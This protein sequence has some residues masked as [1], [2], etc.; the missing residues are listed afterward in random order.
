MA[1][2]RR[3]WKPNFANRLPLN[4]VDSRSYQC[5][6]KVNQWLIQN[7]AVAQYVSVYQFRVCS[8]VFFAIL[9]KSFGLWPVLWLIITS[10]YNDLK[11]LSRHFRLGLWV[12]TLIY[13]DIFKVICRALPIWQWL[14]FRCDEFRQLDI[15]QITIRKTVLFRP[16]LIAI[17]KLQ[18]QVHW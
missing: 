5:P 6:H 4:C 14:W 15:S 8:P 10:V 13:I 1:S 18:C 12:W 11:T 17:N 2:K 16:F 7:V 3:K 9:G